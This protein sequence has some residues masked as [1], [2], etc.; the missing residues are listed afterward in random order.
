MIEGRQVVFVDASFAQ[1]EKLFTDLKKYAQQTL[2][3]FAIWDEFAFTTNSLE[4]ADAILVFN[5]PSHTIFQ[6]TDPAQ[7]LAF[8]M[9][10]GIP[11]LHP[12]MFQGLE[13][14]SKVFSPIASAKNVEQS[15]GFLGWH[16]KKDW[17]YLRSLSF[18]DKTADISCI[19]SDLKQLKGHRLR[20]R[21][22]Q[23]LRLE[24]PQIYF[25]G[26]NVRFVYDK[27][28][29][30]LPYHYSVAIEN[31][32]LPYYFTEKINDC[33]LA[34]TIPI[35]YG[36][37]NLGRFFPEHSF[38]RIDIS[39]P[40]SAI[41][42][43]KDLLLYDD[44]NKRMNALL[45]ARELVLNN[46]QPLAGAAA[47]LRSKQVSTNKTFV[48]LEPITDTWNVKLQAIIRNV[49]IRKNER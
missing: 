2:G 31:S 7:V 48:K 36:C 10:P 34:Y 39:K 13:K 12:W 35:Y 21:F 38:V 29:G 16:V 46:Y 30:L 9:E 25:F 32:A 8:M 26:K 22:V 33:F 40:A 11:R 4:E 28:D 44:T 42:K 1:G 19:A 17:A 27:L 14:Y 5:Q 47:I 37:T 24:M 18:P 15:H 20:N 41:R 43:I 3:K 6:K 23:K 49:L 45:E